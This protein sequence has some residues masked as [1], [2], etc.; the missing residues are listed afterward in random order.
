MYYYFQSNEVGSSVAMELEGLKRSLV[1]L[2]AHDAT[3]SS[4]ITD[5]HSSIK[6]YMREQQ[7]TIKNQFD[8]W[9]VVDKLSIESFSC[10]GL[11]CIYPNNLER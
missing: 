4:F 11:Y 6:K 9:H 8:L 10:R 2:E 1:F 7:P 5:R 3:P